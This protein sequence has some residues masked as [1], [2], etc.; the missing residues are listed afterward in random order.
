MV[1][2]RYESTYR[3]AE[4]IAKI[5]QEHYEAGNLQ[6]CYAAIWRKYIRPR[7]G[8]CYNT[9][10]N[11]L[12]IPTSPSAKEDKDRPIYKLLGV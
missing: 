6:K 11:Y 4:M 9:Y 8:I 10:L 2:K 5:T 12:G 1:K 7:F 3:K